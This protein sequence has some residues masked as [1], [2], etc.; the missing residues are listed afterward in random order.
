MVFIEGDADTFA[1]ILSVKSLTDK[2]TTSATLDTSISRAYGR[3]TVTS[4][5]DLLID[6]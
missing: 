5:H 6:S 4:R 2:E 3:V 1:A